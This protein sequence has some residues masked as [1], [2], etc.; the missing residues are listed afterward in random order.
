MYSLTAVD[1]VHVSTPPNTYIYDIVPIASGLAVISSDDSLRLLDPLALSGNPVNSIRRVNQDVTCLKALNGDV[2]I[3]AGRDAKFVVWDA[4]TGAK[5]GE[6]RC[7]KWSKM[8]YLNSKGLV[9][10]CVSFDSNL[11]LG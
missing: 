4:R 7:G 5:A 8:L 11:D 10:R 9:M 1:A 3:T 6:V 2:V